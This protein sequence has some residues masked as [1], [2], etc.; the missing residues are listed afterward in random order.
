MKRAIKEARSDGADAIV[1]MGHAGVTGIDT[2]DVPSGPLVDIANRLDPKDVDLLLG[3]HTDDE[4]LADAPCVGNVVTDALRTRYATDF[5]I[6]NSGGLRANLTC[7]TVDAPADFCPPFTPPPFP[8]TSGQVLTVLPFG[9]ETATVTLSGTEVRA[10]LERGVS[11]MPVAD[12][13]FPQVSGLCFTYNISAAA[14][15]AAGSRVT[16]AGGDGYPKVIGKATTRAL[17]D[18]DVRDYLTTASP[19]SP[20]V[21]GRINCITTGATAC[22]TVL[23]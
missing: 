18:E 23:P 4:R 11:A 20:A 19:I 2:A 8:I 13:R 12:G 6:T 16:A 7:P 10:F 9:N 17:M 22:P 1:V 5:A 14:A 3:D 15:A 21:Q